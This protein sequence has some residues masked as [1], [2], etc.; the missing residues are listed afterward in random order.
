[1]LRDWE[2]QKLKA[3]GVFE[4]SAQNSG[5]FKLTRAQWALQVW[6]GQEHH[7]VDGLNLHGSGPVLSYVIS[8]ML[9]NIV[10]RD[11]DRPLYELGSSIFI[12]KRRG[13]NL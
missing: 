10:I 7:T 5:S 8:K 2:T 12:V 13:S 1:M 11:V 6:G 9:V 4:I 3:E